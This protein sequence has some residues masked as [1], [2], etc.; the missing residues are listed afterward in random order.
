MDKTERNT[1]FGALGDK[2]SKITLALFESGLLSGMLNQFNKEVLVKLQN[3]QLDEL[4]KFCFKMQEYLKKE[5][6]K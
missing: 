1:I 5:V 3:E 6:F 4:A 2:E